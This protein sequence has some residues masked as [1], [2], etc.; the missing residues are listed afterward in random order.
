M[1]H[2]H[3]LY[4][5]LASVFAFLFLLLIVF[6][7]STA[8]QPLWGRMLLFAL[9]VVI[10]G[11]VAFFAAKGKLNATAT[12]ISTTILIFVLFLVSLVQVVTLFFTTA[13]TV[14]TD[15][16][17]YSR[18][19][20]QIDRVPCVEAVF[21]KSIPED[22][23]NVCFSYTPQFLQGGEVFELSYTTT[24]EKLTQWATILEDKADWFGSNQEWIVANNQGFRGADAVRYQFI[25]DNGNHGEECYVL[26]ESAVNQI[27]FYYSVW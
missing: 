3:A 24:P 18:A 1:K 14:T 25:W 27:T 2:N 23:E 10:F 21:P 13:T 19:F 7:F 9:P 4:P 22:A 8:V 12:I 15:T 6:L 20:N 5:L 26:I 11:M 16:K 17:Y